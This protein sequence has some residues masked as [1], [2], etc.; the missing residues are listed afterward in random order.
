MTSD[1]VAKV[2]AM[3]DKWDSLTTMLYDGRDTIIPSSFMKAIQSKCSTKGELVTDCASYYVN[4][5]PQSSWSFMASHLYREGEFV[6]VVKLKPFLPVKGMHQVVSLLH[7]NNVC[8]TVVCIRCC[9]VHLLQQSLLVG[10][11]NWC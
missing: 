11:A 3:L 10:L 7:Y 1:N 4:C 6:A 5:H 8:T 9:N 2:L